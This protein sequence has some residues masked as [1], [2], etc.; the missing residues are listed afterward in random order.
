MDKQT[1][2]QKEFQMWTGLFAET[3]LETQKAA[4][5]LIQKAAYLHSLFFFVFQMIFK[6]PDHVL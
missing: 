4:E 5:G 2:C 1:K 3:T 6:K